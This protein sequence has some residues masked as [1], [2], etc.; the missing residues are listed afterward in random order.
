M[1]VKY[2]IKYSN[3]YALDHILISDTEL[4][5]MLLFLIEN[6]LEDLDIFVYQI[7]WFC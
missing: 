3:Y 7:I 1:S 4:S 6:C 2:N 5:N